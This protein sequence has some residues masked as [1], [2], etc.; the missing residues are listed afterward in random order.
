MARVKFNPK[1][2]KVD[3]RDS[4]V[5]YDTARRL[6]SS[7]ALT[8][9]YVIIGVK[10]NP[11][12]TVIRETIRHEKAHL[13][14]RAARSHSQRAANE[15]AAYSREKK[16]LSAQA[17]NRIAPM[18]IRDFLPYISWLNKGE[19]SSIK[20]RAMRILSGKAGGGNK[21]A[22]ARARGRLVDFWL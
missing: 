7:V 15:L 6:A 5:I 22:I 11:S 8:S 10:D 1:T 20:A 16:A 18:R 17:W 13:G 9:G 19:Q 21:E 14:S 4:K 12:P 2:M 3:T